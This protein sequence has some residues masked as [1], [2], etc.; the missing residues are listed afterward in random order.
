MDGNRKTKISY[1]YEDLQPSEFLKSHMMDNDLNS[2]FNFYVGQFAS[3]N[4]DDLKFSI[5]M[6]KAL[7]KDEIT[8]DL[9]LFNLDFCKALLGLMGKQMEDKG[10][11]VNKININ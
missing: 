8:L 11:E 5:L 7:T 4:G 10:I 1:S 2:Y 3:A 6:I 9:N